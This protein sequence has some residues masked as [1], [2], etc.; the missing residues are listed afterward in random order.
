MRIHL[1]RFMH[2]LNLLFTLLLL[3]FNIFLMFK[4]FFR[5][6]DIVIHINHCIHLL[7]QPIEIVHSLVNPLILAI[8]HIC[9]D[10][11]SP[12]LITSLSAGSGVRFDLGEVSS[13]Y[14]DVVGQVR[15]QFPVCKYQ[16]TNICVNRMT[17]TRSPKIGRLIVKQKPPCLSPL[18][19]VHNHHIMHHALH[20]PQTRVSEVYLDLPKGLE[21]MVAQKGHG[22]LGLGVIEQLVAGTCVVHKEDGNTFKPIGAVQ[23]FEIVDVAKGFGG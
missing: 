13:P 9:V 16:N 23:G 20:V 12:L 22:S 5:A 6:F 15:L 14:V 21:Y 2:L 18:Y 1:L 11:I 19:R 4:F 8:S 7:S 10:P 17:V 3:R